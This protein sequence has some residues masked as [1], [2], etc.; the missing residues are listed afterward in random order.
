MPQLIVSATLGLGGAILYESTLSY[1]GLGVP[2]PRAA[3]GSMIVRGSFQGAGNPGE[4]S[5]YVGSRR[6][7]DHYNGAWIQLYRRRSA[8][9]LR[10]ENEEVAI[11][12]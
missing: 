11:W 9:C 4:L 7:A 1:L 10:P 8:G 12:H 3:W 6:I 5:K 2:F